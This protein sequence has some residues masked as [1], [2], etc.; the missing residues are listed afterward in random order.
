MPKA[1]IFDFFGVIVSR[2]TPYW[3]GK[4]FP[5]RDY[6][7]MMRLHTIRA[8]KGEITEQQL[9]EDLG[10][11][12]AKPPAEVRQEWF[13]HATLREDTLDLAKRL[14]AHFRTAILTDTPNFLFWDIVGKYGLRQ[15]FEPIVVSSEVKMTKEDPR[16]F[17]LM[18]RNLGI[19]PGDA[20]FTDDK[21]ENVELAR[22]VG[23]RSFVFTDAAQFEKDLAGIGVVAE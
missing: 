6:H 18:L 20:V 15:H 11:L 22:S 14:R 13:D 19:G 23:I 2:I 4:Y 10:A 8:D 1:I 3:F 17:E 21:P 7:E 16:M 5:D 12:V 9:F